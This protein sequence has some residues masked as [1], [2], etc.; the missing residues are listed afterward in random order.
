[1]A[2]KISLPNRKFWEISTVQLPSNR[3]IWYKGGFKT[4]ELA[5]EGVYRRRRGKDLNVSLDRHTTTNQAEM[6]GISVATHLAVQ[7]K[8]YSNVHI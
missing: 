4:G 7:E 6:T 1:M 2:Y 8:S 3:D 5:G